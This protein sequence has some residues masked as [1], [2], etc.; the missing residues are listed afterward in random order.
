MEVDIGWPDDLVEELLLQAIFPDDASAVWWNL[1]TG[2]DL[3]QLWSTLKDNDFVALPGQCNRSSQ[4]TEATAVDDDVE[5]FAHVEDDLR[6]RM[7]E[8]IQRHGGRWEG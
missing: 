1:N 8:R 3:V 7:A 5:G 4:A 6:G 2:T